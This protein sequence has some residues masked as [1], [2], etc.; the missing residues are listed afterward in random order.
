M[1]AEDIINYFEENYKAGKFRKVNLWTGMSDEVIADHI[2]NPEISEWIK[3]RLAALVKI[4]YVY[5]LYFHTSDYEYLKDIVRYLVVLD[6]DPVNIKLDIHKD[7][8]S[9]RISFLGSDFNIFDLENYQKVLSDRLKD[10][11]RIMEND[12]D[13]VFIELGKRCE[14]QEEIEKKIKE[15]KLEDDN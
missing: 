1:T 12:V 3:E 15:F 9:T 6:L 5:S 10:L 2:D 14:M 13:E 8:N 4:E 7:R 11:R